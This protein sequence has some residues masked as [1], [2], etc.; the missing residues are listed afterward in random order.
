MQSI[1]GPLAVKGVHGV[2]LTVCSP[3]T[4]PR[5][6]IVVIQEAFGVGEPIVDVTRKLAAQGYLAIAPHLYH[7]V[8]GE[9]VTTFAKARPLM[10][11]LRGDDIRH[12]LTDALDHATAQGI[13]AGNTGMVGFCMGGTITLWA[14]S[15]WQ[16]A[17]A[18]TFYGSGVSAARWPGVPAGLESAAELRTP[19]LGLYGDKDTSI[20]VDE[21]ETLRGV[22]ADA[23]VPTAIVRYADAGHAFATDPSSPH[24][25]AD[26]ARD[27]WARSLA[28]F[29]AHV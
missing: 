20:S 24:Y 12:D 4:E 29:D 21:V 1:E 25:V 3:G 18:V 16:L 14:A 11:T 2:P 27:A 19:W 28:W 26:A 13:P 22:V 5:G 23:D 15:Q 7:R 6:A 8:A 10:G 17:A 9:A